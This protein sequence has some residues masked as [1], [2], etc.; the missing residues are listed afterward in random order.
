M[1]F[2][3]SPYQF[4]S[5]NRVYRFANLQGET[6]INAKYQIESFAIFRYVTFQSETNLSAKYET[7]TYRFYRFAS[8]QGETNLT[9]KRSGFYQRKASLQGETN[10]S[11]KYF[12][13]LV[14]AQPPSILNQINE[15]AFT[16][17]TYGGRVKTGS[18]ELPIKRILINAP[19]GGIGKTVD[20]ELAEK[21]LALADKNAK[22]KVEVGKG[23]NYQNPLTWVTILDNAELNTRSYSKAWLNHQ[24]SFGVIAPLS[25]KLNRYPF[26]NSIVYDPNKITV[27]ADELEAVPDI[28]GNQII[29]NLR[30]VNVLNLYNLL[31]IA[32]VEGCGFGSVET[33]VPNFE[34]SRCDF[35]FTSS[36]YDSLKPF[37]GIFETI[38]FAVG[39]VLW[40]ID[41]TQPI[42]DDFEPVSISPS[43]F[44]NWR[45]SIPAQKPI[46]GIVLQYVDSKINSTAYFDDLE[47]LPDVVLAGSFGSDD[48]SYKSIERTWRKY[49]HA[50]NPTVV[51][52][53]VLIRSK[54][55][56]YKG[57]TTI[58]NRDTETYTYDAQ[59]KRVASQKVSEKLVPDL[60]NSG[61]MSLLITEIENQSI[62]YKTDRFSPRQMVQDKIITSVTGLI[63][64]DSE[65]KYF[66]EDF[67]QPLKDAHKA[68]NLKSGMT[69]EEGRIKTTI[70]TFIQLGN[71]QMQVI[72]ES[73]DF[74]RNIS[75]TAN[76]TR[77]ANP[78]LNSISGKQSKL[79]IWKEGQS[80]ADHDGNGFDFLTTGEVPLFFAIPL[81]ERLLA[82]R[83]AK[84]EEGTLEIFGFDES[85]DRGVY[86]GVLDDDDNLIG[87]FICEGYS[88]EGTATA[89]GMQWRMR[90]DVT[91]VQ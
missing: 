87:I 10:L 42:P 45:Q 48:Y 28:E 43:K 71:G 81:A 5:S 74:V 2:V 31:N 20:V 46:D 23:G 13:R 3:N 83:E 82:R 37:L 39:N 47:Q 19:V 85:I 41:K 9:A 26:S 91:Q 18:T 50:D 72:T 35:T 51:L 66:D 34:V 24:L 4:L 22:H 36:Y 88:A 6:S 30:P 54:E 67:R 21:N 53:K 7:D 52:D 80:F 32:F 75:A 16:A 70:E 56:T 14:L 59:G 69:A 60:N 89:A 29:T 73:V 40:I 49:Y 15:N 90:I 1:S 58:I 11:A 77:I 86:F 12:Q 44:L 27:S 55:T 78:N 8:F 62:F 68:G 17:K 79:I 76:D 57:L 25:D 61:E 33:N 84:F 65:N 64:V 63:A 38:I